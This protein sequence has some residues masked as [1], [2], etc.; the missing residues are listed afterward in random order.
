MKVSIDGKEVRIHGSR[1]VDLLIYANDDK[2]LDRF[3]IS[4]CYDG[5]EAAILPMVEICGGHI[6]IYSTLEK[7]K[8]LIK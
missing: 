1:K 5:L 2:E 6:V 4:L 8:Q 7:G 3:S